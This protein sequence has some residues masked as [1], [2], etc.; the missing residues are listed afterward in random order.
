MSSLNKNAGFY[1][2]EI[3]Q[4]FQIY[5]QTTDVD[6]AVLINISVPTLGVASVTHLKL[7]LKFFPGSAHLTV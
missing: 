7:E 5:I 2:E 6:G 1:L 4:H 3:A